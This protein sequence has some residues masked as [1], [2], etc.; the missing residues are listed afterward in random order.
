MGILRRNGD[1]KC[2]D[3]DDKSDDL[4][5]PRGYWRQFWTINRS[6][7]GYEGDI[8]R[9]TTCWSPP[10]HQRNAVHERLVAM[11][12]RYLMANHRRDTPIS[13]F[14]RGPYRPIA[15]KFSAPSAP[16]RAYTRAY[17]VVPCRYPQE[18]RRYGIDIYP[19]GPGGLPRPYVERSALT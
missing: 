16:Y 18:P 7:W 17:R 1:D 10:V 5:Q 4:V 2:N 12:H 19:P 14:L 6:N 9:V 13:C 11:S 3:A 15:V 8:R